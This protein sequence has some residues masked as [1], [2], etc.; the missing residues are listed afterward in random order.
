MTGRL[1]GRDN[2]VALFSAHGGLLPYSANMAA[3]TTTDSRYLWCN[4]CSHSINP[5]YAVSVLV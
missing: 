1:T 5:Y 2:V 4:L 3:H